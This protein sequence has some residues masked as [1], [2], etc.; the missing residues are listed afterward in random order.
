MVAGP[1]AH[2]VEEICGPAQICSRR[3]RALDH[4]LRG[5]DAV[6]FV[7][8]AQAGIQGIT[9]GARPGP[10][11]AISRADPSAAETRWSRRD[12]PLPVSW[13]GGTAVASLPVAAPACGP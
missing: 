7:I 8:P 13:S 11:Q 5:D 2:L 1:H 4:R 3:H 12:R 10:C 6:L 9:R